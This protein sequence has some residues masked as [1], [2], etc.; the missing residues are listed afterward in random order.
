MND[1]QHIDDIKALVDGFYGK[2]RTDE[3]LGPIFNHIIQDRWP[4]HFE[5]MVRFWQTV[6]LEEH[7]YFGAPFVP[8][9]KLPVGK[10]HFEHWV[11]LFDATVDELFTGEKAERA[12]WQ[13][14]R[15]AEMFL[16]KIEY[17]QQNSSATPLV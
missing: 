16:I 13:G 17:Y 3:L 5:K 1:I 12:K 8:H 15:M 7:T 11:Q 4:E 2:I 6:L 9:A 10:P 14:R